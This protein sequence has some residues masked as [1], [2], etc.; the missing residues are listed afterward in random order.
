MCVGR[1]GLGRLVRGSG[2][3]WRRGVGQG[4]PG[5]GV[6]ASGLAHGRSL[7]TITAEPQAAPLTI[8]RENPPPWHG[9]RLRPGSGPPGARP[10]RGHAPGPGARRPPGHYV[11][12]WRP[13]SDGTTA[14]S[15][16]A[17]TCARTSPSRQDYER[18]RRDD[19][20]GPITSRA[21]ETCA[22][23]RA[24]WCPC[25]QKRCR[26][27]P[28]SRPATPRT[29]GRPRLEDTMISPHPTRADDR[30]VPGHR[31]W[32]PDHQAGHHNTASP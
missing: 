28:R 31:E 10:G 2:P 20:P 22:P 14:R 30:T 17:T 5:R 18:V 12:R 25:A 4:G 7:R 26:R 3:W 21:E 23:S 1:R 24:T 9:G 32:R 8:S 11:A 27:R 16:S 15:R 19:L 13:A 6:I 29:A